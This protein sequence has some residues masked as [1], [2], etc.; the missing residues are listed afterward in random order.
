MPVNTLRSSSML[1]NTTITIEVLQVYGEQELVDTGSSEVDN[2]TDKP[3]AS[4]A[5]LNYV[6]V[7]HRRSPL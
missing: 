3:L 6:D 7:L 4:K 1:S 5:A 2:A